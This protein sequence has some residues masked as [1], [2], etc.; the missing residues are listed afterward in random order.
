MFAQSHNH[1]QASDS[2]TWEITHNMNTKPSVS[3]VVNIDG[4][5]RQMMPKD[6][7]YLNQNQLRVL[8]SVPRKG[9][10]RCR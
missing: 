9:S 6:V 1:I 10:A 5:D 8:W 3:C 2:D 7:V 4:A